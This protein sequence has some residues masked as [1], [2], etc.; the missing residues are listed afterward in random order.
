MVGT[1]C[2]TIL[3]ISLLSGVSDLFTGFEQSVLQLVSVSIVFGTCPIS[4]GSQN[5]SLRSRCYITAAIPYIFVASRYSLVR[6]CYEFNVSVCLNCQSPPP[7]C[8]ICRLSAVRSCP[9]ATRRPCPSLRAPS[10]SL[11][12]QMTCPV[13]PRATLRKSLLC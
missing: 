2:R 9:W 10:S 12:P 13:T 11:A 7:P 4:V 3:L 6:Q 5:L 8:L 1:P